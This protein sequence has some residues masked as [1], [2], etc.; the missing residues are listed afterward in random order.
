[1][2]PPAFALNPAQERALAL[3]CRQCVDA[4]IAHEQN[5][6]ALQGVRSELLVALTLHRIAMR[7]PKDH[8][9]PVEQL[10]ALLPD[11]QAA[12][13]AVHTIGERH[14]ATGRLGCTAEQREGLLLLAEIL[15]AMR[16]NI[17]RR[18]WLRAYREAY[19]R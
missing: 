10:T 12:S 8:Q 4:L 2:I 15:D 16:A 13:V 3:R 6:E 14:K 17:P 5:L 18:L 1:M 9:V 19:R 11:L 7:H